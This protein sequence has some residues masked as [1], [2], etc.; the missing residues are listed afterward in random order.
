M[1]RFNFLSDYLCIIAGS[2]ILAVAINFFL[3]PCKI[4]TGGVSGL[5]TLV[6]YVFKIPLSVTTIAI[7]SVLFVFGIK[8]LPKYQLAK[9]VA[10]VIF[11]SLFLEMTSRY[12]F[13]LNDI[14][15]SS[16]F[17]G[18]LIGFG[19]A[20][21]ILKGA[22]TG[23]TD[24]AAIMLRKRFRHISI[25]TFMLI[26]DLAVI[27]ISG[28]VFKNYLIMFY[29]TVSLYV[30]IKVTDFMLVRGDF[31]K[32]VYIISQKHK[33]VAD[34]IQNKIQRGVTG[35]YAKGLYS[36][37]DGMMLM[38]ILKSKEVPKLIEAIKEIDVDAFTIISDI[39][40]VHGKG[41]RGYK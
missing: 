4:S 39:R 35:I 10:G 14:F 15:I 20:L 33:R 36:S 18:V 5:A 8:M 31:A 9:T 41:F 17:G 21:T 32:C 34:C 3:V 13:Y 26:I 6:Y 12:N 16:V 1:K 25:A 2:F 7:N 19:V 23:G 24:F 29:S 28:I 40:Q 37:C 22:S 38:C 27:V 30:V 11:L